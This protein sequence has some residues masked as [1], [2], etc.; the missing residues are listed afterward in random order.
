MAAVAHVGC[1]GLYVAVHFGLAAKP[2]LYPFVGCTP[3]PR[4]FHSK[5]AEP[6]AMAYSGIT[7]T[8]GGK[9]HELKF[10]S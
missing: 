1:D 3:N 6:T 9:R 7:A 4:D 5:L 10:S 8:L 2:Q